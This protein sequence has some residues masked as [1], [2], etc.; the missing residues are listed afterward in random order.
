MQRRKMLLHLVSRSIE[1]LT[2]IKYKL[3]QDLLEETPLNPSV[4]LSDLLSKILDAIAEV[5]KLA[6]PHRPCFTAFYRYRSIP[7]QE[8][9]NIIAGESDRAEV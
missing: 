2:N 8:A 9:L 5:G 4:S 6:C 7:K 1:D 3:E